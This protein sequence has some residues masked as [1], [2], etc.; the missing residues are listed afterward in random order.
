[1]RTTFLTLLVFLGPATVTAQ[2]CTRSIGYINVGAK[3][4]GVYVDTSIVSGLNTGLFSS[5]T[6]RSKAGIFSFS[7]CA[8]TPFEVTC[9]VSEVTSVDHFSY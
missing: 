8:T 2:T 7:R 4:S 5:T 9:V 3:T 1:M 6:D